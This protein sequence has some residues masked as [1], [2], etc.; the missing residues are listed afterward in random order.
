MTGKPTEHD[1][2]VAKVNSL[3]TTGRDDMVDEM[4][5]QYVHND[6]SGREAFWCGSQPGWPGNQRR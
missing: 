2:Y 4:V 6:K 5:S 1:R 3:V